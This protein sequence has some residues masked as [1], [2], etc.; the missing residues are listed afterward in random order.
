MVDAE[1]GGRAGGPID[2]SRC[3]SLGPESGGTLVGPANRD[4]DERAGESPRDV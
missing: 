1:G 2:G 3:I 4:D